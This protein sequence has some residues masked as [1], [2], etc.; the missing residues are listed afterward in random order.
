M[1]HMMCCVY[2]GVT[3]CFYIVSV[4]H[5]ACSV[6]CTCT[7]YCTCSLSCV[8]ICVHLCLCVSVLLMRL[9][10]CVCQCL[11]VPCVYLCVRVLPASCVRVL[12]ASCVCISCVC[13][14][15]LRQRF[16]A[17]SRHVM[18]FCDVCLMIMHS[19]SCTCV[20]C[21]EYVCYACF[22]V[23]GI[24]LHFLCVY[25]CMYGNRICFRCCLLF[26]V[27]CSIFWFLCFCL[28]VLNSCD[29]RLCLVLCLP[30]CH[31]FVLRLVSVFTCTICV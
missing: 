31:L 14:S 16:C 11:C 13:T 3:F 19:C 6:C 12:P 22:G 28:G 27:C 18:M 8:C 10:L 20:L 4:L 29:V 1:H 26:L 15:C 5:M 9:Y 30:Y 24:V 23:R 21:L 7:A 2:V 17:T 25:V